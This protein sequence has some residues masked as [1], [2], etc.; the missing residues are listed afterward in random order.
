MTGGG[1]HLPFY[2]MGRTFHFLSPRVNKDHVVSR[3]SSSVSQQKLNCV[4]RLSE[5]T[6]SGP[7]QVNIPLPFL[8]AHDR[9]Y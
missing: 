6:P 9:L 7:S 4:A 3:S 5:Q 1:M 8:F 2:R